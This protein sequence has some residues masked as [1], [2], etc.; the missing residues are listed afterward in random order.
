MKTLDLSRMHVTVDRL[1]ELAAAGSIRILTADGRA[2]VLEAADDF[3]KEVQLLG[4]SAKFRRFLN[5]RSKE[6]ATTSLEA[7]RRS[8]D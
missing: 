3:D 7:Y 8:L 2:F 6:T 5:Q 4:K 1:L